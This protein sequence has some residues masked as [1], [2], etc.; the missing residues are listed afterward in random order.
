MDSFGPNIIA[1]LKAGQTLRLDDIQADP[2][3]APYAAGYASIGTTSLLVVPLVKGGRLV[4]ILY[5]HCAQPR[6]W[7]D[8]DALIA[9]D[10]AQR[11]WDAIERANAQ[12][13][14][15]IANSRK[16]EFLA[17]LA[18]ELRNPLAP[19][20]GA[21]Q[22]LEL[23]HIDGTRMRELGRII[24][25]QVGHMTALLNDLLDVSRVTRGMIEL[26][27]G[28]VDMRGVV[29]AASEQVRP[30]V[31]QRRHVLAYT[32]PAVPTV[33][34]GDFVRLVQILAN[35]IN[36]AAK[37]TPDSGHIG[38]V[39]TEQSESIRVAVTDNGYGIAPDLLPDVFDSFIQ[40]RRT[41]GRTQGGLGL[42]LALVKSLVELHDGRVAASSRGERQGTTITIELPRWHGGPPRE[43]KRPGD[44]MHTVGTTS[45]L[46]ILLVDDN[47]DG[48]AMLARLIGQMGHRVTVAHN[49]SSALANATVCAPD[50]VLL[51]IGL[52][53]IDGY[54]LVARLRA[55]P[56]C[57]NALYIAVTGYGQHQ[58]RQRALDAGFWRHMTKPACLQTLAGY[59]KEASELAGPRPRTGQ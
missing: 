54:E 50:V 3:S 17:M 20:D 15:R 32:A 35:V 46:S 23:G 21:A 30:L 53:D 44:A 4:A 58:D 22:L 5:L 55:Q 25:R 8:A 12:S 41:L 43:G 10:V 9:E 49:A 7:S 57:G 38:V 51:D 47:V 59:L 13:A 2:R 27:L 11:T 42:G 34:R 48:A 29:E 31:E 40:G 24:S 19:I 33:V 36:N 18:H 6:R 39:L 52:P 16:D 37:Y 56:V 45:A 26:D 1:V 14:L 28:A